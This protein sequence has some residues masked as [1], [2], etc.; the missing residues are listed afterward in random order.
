VIR[1][2]YTLKN[3]DPIEL[4]YFKYIYEN[5]FYIGLVE[6]ESCIISKKN[7]CDNMLLSATIF[8]GNAHFVVSM[9]LLGWWTLLDNM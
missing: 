9:A 8:F 4:P 3:L 2:L 1:F 7:V 6:V 5:L